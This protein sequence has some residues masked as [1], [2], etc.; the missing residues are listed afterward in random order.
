MPPSPAVPAL[1]LVP[2]VPAAPSTAPRPPSPQPAA[3]TADK[4]TAGSAAAPV[5]AAQDA[6]APAGGAGEES[7]YVLATGERGRDRLQVSEEAYGWATTSLVRSLTAAT[8][9]AWPQSP[10]RMAVLACGVG[11]QLQNLARL[12]GPG[13]SLWCSDV[14][15]A[16]LEVAQRAATQLGAIDVHFDVVDLERAP[17]AGTFDVVHAR[18][19]LVHLRRPEAALRNMWQ[20]VRPRGLLVSEEHAI[21]G[22]GAEP[23]AEA[24][25]RAKGWLRALGAQRGVDF[26]LGLRL[27]DL[28]A[29]AQVPLAEVRSTRVGF[30]EGAHKRLLASSLR[31]GSQNYV[32]AG[33]ATQRE[34]DE[35]CG[36]L[37]AHAERPDTQLFLGV[38]AQAWSVRTG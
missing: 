9:R 7:S 13:S 25:D 23:P 11:S 10:M 3:A 31:E 8:P 32:A 37:D 1:R 30:R 6:A 14:D 36:A 35:V 29:R 22:I 33:I 19:V 26:D 18:F 4:T 38:L 34:L 17:A 24:I 28:F 20:M 12:A 27:P 5:A 16:Q 2:T 21:D 15:R